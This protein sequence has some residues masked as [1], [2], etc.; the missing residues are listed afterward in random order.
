[1]SEERCQRV[2]A[3]RPVPGDLRDP[4]SLLT[5]LSSRVAVEAL[6]TLPEVDPN[7]TAGDTQMHAAVGMAREH[8]DEAGC[9]DHLRCPENSSP[10]AFAS[11]LAA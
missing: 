11:N 2:G 8:V 4:I 3:R 6:R 7:G 9:V 1:M 5:S 10:H